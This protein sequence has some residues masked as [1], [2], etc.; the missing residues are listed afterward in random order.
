[1]SSTG[2]GGDFECEGYSST[3]KLILPNLNIVKDALINMEADRTVGQEKLRLL[4]EYYRVGEER[5]EEYQLVVSDPNTRRQKTLMDR[6]SMCDYIADLAADVELY[7]KESNSNTTEP[8][9]IE[10]YPTDIGIKIR[11]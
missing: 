9:I 10:P 7:L 1:M 4:R 6:S 5:P 3:V 8:T 11:R 2:E